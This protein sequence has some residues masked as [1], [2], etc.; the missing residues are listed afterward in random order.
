MC[1]NVVRSRVQ[2]RE[3]CVHGVAALLIMAVVAFPTFVR[4]GDLLRPEH[5]LFADL[6]QFQAG[7]A[8]IVSGSEAELYRGGAFDRALAAL[9]PWPERLIYPAVYPAH[10]YAAF[11]PLTWLPFGIAA[12]V[13]SVGSALA[14]V[15]AVKL[16]NV[17]GRAI[18]MAVICLAL[19]NPAF[20]RTWVAGQTGAF[21]LLALILAWRSWRSNRMFAAGLC[22]GALA[23]KPQLLAIAACAWMLRPSSKLAAGVMLAVGAHLLAMLGMVGVAGFGEYLSLLRRA[24]AHPEV[25]SAPHQFISVSGALRLAFGHTV[26][27]WGV[28]LGSSVTLVLSWRL[29]RRGTK[30]DAF[31]AAVLSGL[32][33]S[34]HV[35]AYDALIFGAFLLPLCFD[36]LQRGTTRPSDTIAYILFW[37]PFMVGMAAATRVQATPLLALAWLWLRESELRTGAVLAAPE[38]SAT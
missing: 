29:T 37:A 6:L 20:W 25:F 16:A 9:A 11:V 15:G 35:Y 26:P 23:W 27:A 7:A 36:T 14:Y 12:I 31:A 28:A 8:L 17:H 19:G 38:P 22:L 30:E 4:A 32:L 5:P 21:S 1:A 34:P 10:V 13:F 33:L 18:P 2:R 3:L 24:A